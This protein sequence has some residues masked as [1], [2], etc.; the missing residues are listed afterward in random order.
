MTREQ[1]E[2]E[3]ERNREAVAGTLEELH[4][5]L[6]P[7]ELVDQV[8]GYMEGGGNEFLGNLGRQVTANPMPITLI[9]AGLAWFVFAK[10]PPSNE[11]GTYYAANNGSAPRSG[12]GLGDRARSAANKIGDMASSAG[13]EIGGAVHSAQETASSVYHET[14]DKASQAYRQAAD[15]VA[16]AKNSVIELENKAAEAARSAFAFCREEPL[17]LV[18]LGLALGA[19]MGAALPATEMEN[20]LMGEASDQLKDAAKETASDQLDKAKQYGHQMGEKVSEALTEDVESASVGGPMP[21]ESF[22]SQQQ[23]YGRNIRN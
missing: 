4:D 15:T 17:V 1:L 19:A 21:A 20:E 10:N 23:S 6:T 9:G 5:R 13:E 8:L 18:G 2:Q 14:A 7:G 22:G 11:A 16:M 3:A 12:N